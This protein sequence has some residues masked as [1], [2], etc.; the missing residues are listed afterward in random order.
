MDYVLNDIKARIQYRE[1]RGINNTARGINTEYS[2]IEYSNTASDTAAEATRYQLASPE[3][4]SPV[5]EPTEEGFLVKEEEV[6]ES[7]PSAIINPAGTWGLEAQ[8]CF[9]ETKKVK[10]TSFHLTWQFNYQVEQQ[11]AAKLTV[12]TY[13]IDRL[14]EYKPENDEEAQLLAY[15]KSEKENGRIL[16]IGRVVQRGPKGTAVDGLICFVEDCDGIKLMT[17]INIAANETIELI[18]DQPVTPK[19]AE[20]YNHAAKLYG[21]QLILPGKRRRVSIFEITT[22]VG[23]SK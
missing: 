4:S 16:D 10:R 11:K 9:R 15:V 5:G 2:N 19:Q 8:Q 21:N 7:P 17:L 18:F 12:Y 3:T 6:K 1:D 20:H 23:G 22:L 13:P 14:R